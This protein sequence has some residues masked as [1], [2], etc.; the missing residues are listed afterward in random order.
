LR[1]ALIIAV[2]IVG[3][4]FAAL[5][6]LLGDTIGVRWATIILAGLCVGIGTWYTTFQLDNEKEDLLRQNELYS[7]IIG[8][9]QGFST[10][11][12]N[13]IIL[14]M[15][16]KLR[17]HLSV[18]HFNK[19]E[20]FEATLADVADT[21]ELLNRIYSS[22]SYESGTALYFEG[23]VARIRKDRENMRGMFKRYLGNADAIPESRIGTAAPSYLTNVD[24]YFG[25]RTA[26]IM[27]IMANDFYKE[28]Q[29]ESNPA[30]RK[31]GLKI[32]LSYAADSMQLCR[33]LGITN[34]FEPTTSFKATDN[35]RLLSQAELAKLP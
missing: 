31:N 8:S 13:E 4:I 15:A 21:C 10:S 35:V 27:H 22:S 18:V 17:K 3:V 12:R 16:V 26:W 33:S 23:E 19:P 20:D 25:E 2:T 5:P 11:T 30:A 9:A 24:G 28:A 7:E 6:N 14:N 34:G 32:A 1:P 29:G